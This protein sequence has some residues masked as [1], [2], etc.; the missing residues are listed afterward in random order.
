MTNYNEKYHTC[1]VSFSLCLCLYIYRLAR[2]CMLALCSLCVHEY[3]SQIYVHTYISCARVRVQTY[4]AMSMYT[5]ISK[6][7]SIS[8]F[9][10][11]H[12]YT[13]I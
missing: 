5:S 2:T 10:S 8:V 4:L 3:M 7:I 6:S 12:T 1:L 11:L 13:Y 9:L